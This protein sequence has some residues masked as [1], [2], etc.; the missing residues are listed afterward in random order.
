LLPAFEDELPKYL[1]ALGRFVGDVIFAGVTR[2]D[3]VPMSD[4][5]GL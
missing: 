2:V 3:R 5:G 4:E 1:N